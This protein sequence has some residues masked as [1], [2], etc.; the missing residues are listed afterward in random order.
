M[1]TKL[2]DMTETIEQSALAEIKTI[3]QRGELVAFPTETVYG[4]GAD[5]TN[6]LA[7]QRIFAAKGRPSDN[8]LIVHVASKRQLLTLVTD[9]P[10]YVETL[11]DTFSPG[12]I[13]YVLK[14]ASN[15]GK[16]VTAGLNTIGIRIPNH[17]VALAIL[18]TIE[19]PIAAPSA[20]RS[21]KPSPTRAIHVLEDLAG[22][23]AC[24]VDGGSTNIGLESTVVDCT[25]SVPFILRP[26]AITREQIAEVVGACD[27]YET[28]KITEQPKSPG[29]K[30]VHYA[31]EAPLMLVEKSKIAGVI[32]TLK[33]K[34]MALLYLSPSL[35]ETA[36][37][38]TIF[39][40]DTEEEIAKH[41]YDILRSLK[42]DKFDVI[43]CEMPTLKEES[44]LV[45]RLKRAATEVV[46]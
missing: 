10:D 5:A 16:T 7:V 38:E 29:M 30:Y 32:S 6:E 41:L 17:P 39:L 2:I 34:R 28:E 13:T 42:K 35:K 36:V 18:E 27:I 37:E 3:L 46:T 44:A 26:G 9:V 40:G 31:P 43:L 25:K 1:K 15:L 33:G 11:I 45:D 19:R 4:L 8:P 12:P 24:I 20:N 22:K 14:N 21:G 23:I